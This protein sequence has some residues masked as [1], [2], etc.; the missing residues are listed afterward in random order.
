MSNLKFAF[1]MLKRNP[2]LVY[3]SIPGLAIGLSALLLLAV[4]LKYEFSFDK[5][6]PTNNRVLRLCNI[7]HG[8]NGINTLSIGLRTDYT[9]LPQ[10]VPEVERAV[11][12]YP[13]WDVKIKAEKGTFNDLQVMFADEEFFDVFGVRLLEGTSEALAGKKNIILT[14]SSAEKLFGSMDCVGRTLTLDDSDLFVT[15]VMADLPKTT[16]FKFDLL[17]PMK[18]NDFIISQ[19]SLEF[20]TYYLIK[21]GV[22]LQT[23]GENIAAVNN[24][25]MKVWKQRGKLNDTKSETSTEL[26]RN[27]HLYTKTD[28]DMVQKAN[29][30]QLFI[31]SGIALFIFLI[32]LINFVNMYLLHGEK[33]IAEIASRKVA[34]ATSGNLAAQ[35]FRENG[36]IAVLALLAAI[37]LTVLVQ[38]FF[39]QMINLPLAVDDMFTPLGIATVVGILILLVLLAGTYPG[40]HL[41]KINLISGLKGKRQNITHGGLSKSVVLVQFF[42]TVLLISSLIIIRAQI[43]HMKDVP[44]GFNEKNV[45]AVQ[46]F[47]GQAVKNVVSIKNELE[48][49]PFIQSVG[50]SQHR[51][52]G[53][54]S[55]Q[56]IAL[57]NSPDEKPV[58]EYR[59]MPGFTETMQ[60]QLKEGRYFTDRQDDQNSI[61]IN[62]AAAK[63]LDLQFSPGMQVLYKG[64]PVKVTGIIK[65]FYFNGYAGKQIDPLVL[66]RTDYGYLIYLR[67][68][69]SFSQDNQKQV[70][71]IIQSFDPDYMMSFASLDDVY[72]AK[73]E[74]DERAFSM[75]SSGAVLAI[76]LSFAGMLA[77]SILNVTRRIKEIGIRKVV[78]STEFEI[79]SKLLGE[80]FLLVSIASLFAF[81]IS[82]LLMTNW[83]NNFANKI[84]IGVGYF[85][86]SGLFAFFIAFLAVGW[87][88]WRAATRNPAEAL[89]N[90]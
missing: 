14:R 68:K 83:L 66:S 77:L 65:D 6:F 44:L 62:E 74:K 22:N 90:E 50:I 30:M 18:A 24:E 7:L 46:D 45:V 55:G 81:G 84:N 54:C 2:L 48:S 51:M 88:S 19:G 5:H 8:E 87:Q 67:T 53:G 17:Q 43:K 42:I 39:S 40:F 56:S 60:I 16:H 61:L 78:G 89:R 3:I 59:V 4:Y 32:A 82:Y 25:L 80:T 27:I 28:E 10:Q 26:L 71:S 76:I 70:A 75:V 21:K 57:L 85:L 47:S 23:A 69:G 15:G 41:S 11:Q 38:P 49:L 52:G 73:F 34:G 29:W 31:V 79:M 63:M 33:R 35:F 9:Q 1:R 36:I 86:F 20:Q 72:T 58:N 37:W 64:K 13:G 12:L